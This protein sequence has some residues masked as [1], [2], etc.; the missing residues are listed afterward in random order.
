MKTVGFISSLSYSLFQITQGL[1]FHPYQT[2]QSLVRE[3]VFSW[4]VWLPTVTVGSV[5]IVWK[6]AIVP[7]VRLL[8]SCQESTFQI[9]RVLPPLSNW[10][11]F[12]CLYWQ[13]LLGYLWIRFWLAERAKHHVT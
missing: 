12:F 10:L 8:F 1:F 3:Q 2:T 4:M 7:L 13:L 6:I 5:Y 11:V 9:C